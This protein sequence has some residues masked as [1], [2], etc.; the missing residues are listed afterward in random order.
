VAKVRGPAFSSRAKGPVGEISFDRAGPLQTVKSRPTPNATFGPE[1]LQVH[2]NM[3]VASQWWQGL[4]LVHKVAWRAYAMNHPVADPFCGRRV[5]SARS[6]FLSF[7]LRRLRY[8]VAPPL[9][10]PDDYPV[11]WVT[12][13]YVFEPEGDED[14][15]F[16][17]V[18]Q[19]PEVDYGF[20]EIFRSL[21]LP[22]TSESFDRRRLYF[23]RCQGAATV[24]G[25]LAIPKVGCKY[26]VR[27]NYLSHSFVPAVPVYFL[28]DAPGLPGA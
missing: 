12:D 24:E 3:S 11:T 7:A 14:L 2:S 18:L 13:F 9:N 6:M 4:S 5:L 28:V 20:L 21:P 19:N 17:V 22:S 1:Y 16:Q 25:V 15:R 10:P 23:A 26:G 27:V 8:G